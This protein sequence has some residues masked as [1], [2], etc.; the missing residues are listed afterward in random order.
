MALHEGPLR[1]ETDGHVHGHEGL[2][3]EE[4]EDR[5]A[6]EAQPATAVLQAVALFKLV[7]LLC[8]PLGRARTAVDAEE[9]FKP[10][11]SLGQLHDL[12]VGAHEI[13]AGVAS[14][15]LGFFDKVEESKPHGRFN[16][17]AFV[18]H[19]VSAIGSHTLDGTAVKLC[20]VV[21]TCEYGITNFEST[22][23]LG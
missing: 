10:R 17:A 19:V 9:H 18:L 23:L 1:R 14:H 22:L 3:D 7:G 11:D 15:L 8:E 21:I 20:T 13:R 4:D 16:I 12:R 2:E 6:E 5:E